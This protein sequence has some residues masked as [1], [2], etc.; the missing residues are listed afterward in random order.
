M[1]IIKLLQ[2]HKMRVLLWLGLKSLC[3]CVCVRERN[4]IEEASEVNTRNAEQ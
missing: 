3:V 2:W 1:C 4:A